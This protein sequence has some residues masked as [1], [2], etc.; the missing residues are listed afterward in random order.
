MYSAGIR[1]CES[2]WPWSLVLL[3]LRRVRGF[4]GCG[5]GQIGSSGL[6]VFGIEDASISYLCQS[7]WLEGFSFEG[8]RFYF[9]C[10]ADDREARPFMQL[11]CTGHAQFYFDLLGQF[12][13]CGSARNSVSLDIIVIIELEWN[14]AV[15][16]FACRSAIQHPPV[17]SDDQRALH[18]SSQKGCH[19]LLSSHVSEPCIVHPCMGNFG[20]EAVG[21]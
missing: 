4:E 13:R 2:A 12:V 14:V 9:A 19:M 6:D 16:P 3:D 17:C 21:Q 18:S 10:L 5:H 11:R 8:I 7:F 20:F 15:K 1:A